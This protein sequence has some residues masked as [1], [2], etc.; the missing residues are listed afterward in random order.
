MSD[1]KSLRTL[2]FSSF[3]VAFKIFSKLSRGNFASIHKLFKEPEDFIKQSTLQLF[4][5]VFGIRSF[6]WVN[7][8]KLNFQVKL[9][10]IFLS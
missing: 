4:E 6:L 7:G 9:H 3:D 5:R 1:L 8:L 10:Q 2:F